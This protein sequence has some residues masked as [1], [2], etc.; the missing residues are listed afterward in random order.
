[1]REISLND[2]PLAEYRNTIGMVQATPA[3]VSLPESDRLYV[4]TEVVFGPAGGT[5]TGVNLRGDGFQKTGSAG[6]TIY[7][8][9]FSAA[10]IEFTNLLEY[11]GYYIARGRSRV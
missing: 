10:S 11:G 2:L 4:I 9:P 8:F 5:I 7:C 1:M 3:D 6:R